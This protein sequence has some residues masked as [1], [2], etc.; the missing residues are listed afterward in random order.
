LMAPILHQPTLS[1]EKKDEMIKEHK[2]TVDEALNVN[3]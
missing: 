1:V 3:V 2:K